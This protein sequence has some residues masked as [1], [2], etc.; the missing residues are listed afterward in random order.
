MNNITVNTT[1]EADPRIVST[2]FYTDSI[3][4]GYIKGHIIGILMDTGSSHNVISAK[5][6]HKIWP[7]YKKKINRLPPDLTFQSVCGKD[8]K[9]LGKIDIAVHINNTMCLCEF[10]VFETLAQSC[11]LGRTFMDKYSAELDFEQSTLRFS[12][13]PTIVNTHTRRIK[14][15]ETCLLQAECDK[16]QK[17]IMPTGLHGR[18]TAVD[19]N[20]GVTIHDTLATMADN[21]ICVQLHN[22]STFPV[23][24]RKGRKLATFIP[25]AE[26]ECITLVPNELTNTPNTQTN[27][28]QTGTVHHFNST[29]TRTNNPTNND[30]ACQTI[31]PSY[32]A[33]TCPTGH[34]L[35]H[36]QLP[37]DFTQS[38]C[39][40]EELNQLK[41]ILDDHTAAFIDS[42]GDIGRCTVGE[43][44]VYLKPNIIPKAS[45][46]YR[47]APDVKET[48]QK[49]IDRLLQMGI[50]TEMDS[51]WASPVVAVKKQRK[52]SQKH[53]YT[54]ADK[55]EIRLC[56][57]YRWL[58]AC[59][60]YQKISIPSISELID[61][62]G[63]KQPNYVSSLDLKQAYWQVPL[64]EDSV[65]LTAFLFG[66]RS[67]AWKTMPMGI[68]GAPMT[69]QRIM[70]K[71]LCK[72]LNKN[73]VCYLDDVLIF[74][75][76]FEEHLKAVDEV[77]QAFEDVNM[78]LSPSKCTF[79]ANEV[80]FLGHLI[81]PQGISVAPSHVSS[82]LTFPV[83]K[84]A[85]QLRTWNGLCCF[86]KSFI[87]NRGELMKPLY[88]L[89]KKD[90]AD[91]F[92][93]TDTA[94][95]CFE[96]LKS[97]LTSRPLLQY[98]DYK[99][100]FHVICDASQ[101]SIGAVLAQKDEQGNYKPIAFFGRSTTDSERR[102][103]IMEIECL[104][105]VVA[106]T[107]WEIY[108]SHQPFSV[109]TDNHSLKHLLA[110]KVKMSPKLQRWALYMSKFE[111]EIVFLR[112]LYNSCADGLS[113]R[114]YGFSRVKADDTLDDFPY[115]PGIDMIKLKRQGQ[116][117]AMTRSRSQQLHQE[118]REAEIERERFMKENLD[119]PQHQQIPEE[120]QGKADEG[121]ESPDEFE[122]YEYDSEEEEE[123][124]DREAQSQAP[125]LP[126]PPDEEEEEGQEEVAGKVKKNTPIQR[127]PNARRD[128]IPLVEQEAM[129]DKIWTM[130]NMAHIDV[131]TITKAQQEDPWCR[132]LILYLRDD[133]LPS[134]QRRQRRCILR[135]VD[136][137]VHD[138]TLYHIW[139][140]IPSSRQHVFIRLVVPKSLTIEVI[141]AV[142][143]STIGTH[144][145]VHKTIGILKQKFSWPGLYADVRT[146]I[147]ACDLCQA[148]KLSQKKE[149]VP[150]TLYE[151]TTMP[152]S[153]IHIDF[154]GPYEQSDT[155]KRYCVTVV[156]STTGFLITWSM[157][158][159]LTAAVALE[160][161]H[162]VCCTYSTPIQCV[163]DR[164]PQFTSALWEE[165]GQLMNIKMTKTSAYSP[166]SNGM[167]EI[168]NRDITYLLRC[169]VKKN[170]KDW[171]RFLPAVTM[172][173]NSTIHT[174]HGLTP[175]NILYGRDPITPIDHDRLMDFEAQPLTSV[176]QDILE[177]Q[178]RA[179]K[180][181]IEL[182]EMRDKKLKQ[183]HDK[184]VK[185]SQ[186][187]AGDVVFWFKPVLQQVTE[188]KKLQNPY[189]GPFLI[190][191][192]HTDGTVTMRHLHTG[193]YV[194]Q[195][196]HISQLKR[197][198]HYRKLKR[199]IE[200]REA[201]QVPKQVGNEEATPVREASKED[202]EE[203]NDTPTLPQF[204]PK[205]AYKPQVREE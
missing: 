9:P 24:M 125:Q 31:E 84:T 167:A 86:F 41:S 34:N 56:I 46:P 164:G 30:V 20:R 88:D 180:I 42:S 202:R 194:P 37:F 177:Q 72:Q 105:V 117:T 8:M 60:L 102:R 19:L 192:R 39:S 159:I 96:K 92:K 67:Y 101:N 153:R 124:L 17:I 87:P 36:S 40:S 70:N 162:R 165:L 38:K 2:H 90:V 76:T 189:R 114:E 123:P 151:I 135:E 104:A 3:I 172:S 1:S 12:S 204:A 158:N 190:V 115:L 59:S 95:K 133:V 187:C 203:A 33:S 81:T 89:T 15:G 161:Y 143:C 174:A 178:Q 147:A 62:I 78:K 201:R 169:M 64:S 27:K 120:E 173:L 157:R 5:L 68:S 109:T 99:K 200:A 83:P 198:T 29:S 181:A 10:I 4:R 154:L 175:Y 14:P 55:P 71:V 54:R 77:L 138:S 149:T 112:G 44:K 113:R 146:F 13:T 6:L 126:P 141:R 25:I 176:I 69:F 108:L 53:M 191:T 134:T 58:N 119:T 160:F 94:Q 122:I 142:H 91:K 196:V 131:H 195:K 171:D 66:S 129:V 106:V 80:T 118:D 111:Y 45:M 166:W 103:P 73:V 48:I 155:Q 28:E 93:W 26:S 139:Q 74:S 188:N 85:S 145:G 47:L 179:L 132:D 128:D 136:Y 51:L 170:K 98:P 79:A 186:L 184:K 57:D 49:Q 43:H 137:C 130:P 7:Q 32:I 144:T 75:D 197:P 116:I 193:K 18:I 121:D 82:I 152:W 63:Q 50:L 156:D 168:R 21:K 199:A 150:R 127:L 107:N 97:I 163:S 35:T 52:K 205:E 100:T 16:N 110:N 61:V 65:P 140:P 11:I 22:K 148:A 185:T 183:L 182:H 23:I